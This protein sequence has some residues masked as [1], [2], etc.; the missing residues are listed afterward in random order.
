MEQK[1]LVISNKRVSRIDADIIRELE[2]DVYTSNH[3]LNVYLWSRGIRKMKDVVRHER[4]YFA[5][6]PNVGRRRLKYLDEFVYDGFVKLDY[7]M[8]I[9]YYEIKKLELEKNGLKLTRRRTPQEMIQLFMNPV[10]DEIPQW[11]VEIE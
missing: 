6:I 8:D 7:G 5:S 9:D 2:L 11:D 4:S 10:G 3:A 1:D